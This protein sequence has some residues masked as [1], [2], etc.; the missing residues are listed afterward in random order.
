MTFESEGLLIVAIY[1]WLPPAS[2]VV[3]SDNSGWSTCGRKFLYLARK[4]LNI[5]V[6]ASNQFAITD[7]SSAILSN[8]N[9]TAVYVYPFSENR[10]IIMII[11]MIIRI[12]IKDDKQDYILGISKFVHVNDCLIKAKFNSLINIKVL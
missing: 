1:I 8:T 2:Y 9:P 11:R 4:Y 12:K 3:F 10:I 6:F 7:M 5:I